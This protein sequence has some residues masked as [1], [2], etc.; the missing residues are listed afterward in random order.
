MKKGKI[1]TWFAEV[2]ARI[3]AWFKALRAWREAVKA[4]VRACREKQTAE[5]G[6]VEANSKRI[7]IESVTSNFLDVWGFGNKNIFVTLK[8]LFWRP[9]FM[10]RDYLEGRR[11]RLMQPVMMLVV[12]TLGLMLLGKILPV[13]IMPRESA[14]LH[15]PEARAQLDG[16]NPD[17]AKTL[18]LL[19]AV[20]QFSMY[21][22]K[23]RQWEEEH[24]DFGLLF[25]FS[26]TML[27]MWLLFRKVGDK[28]YNFAEIMTVV[29]Y[30][31]CQLQVISIVWLLCTAWWHPQISFN[32]FIFP[33]YIAHIVFFIDFQQ[34]FQRR[35]WST[36]WRTI[37]ALFFVF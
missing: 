12:L 14:T 32:P 25:K 11:G 27:L 1:H 3:K 18:Q 30:A 16:S 34:L 28:T 5:Y 37:V 15:F 35:W 29:C 6:E 13:E 24:P 36:L 20:E 10:M 26:I 8:H 21:M 2:D 17:D 9:G 4:R 31:I 22:E 23:I 33:F 7:T 19:N